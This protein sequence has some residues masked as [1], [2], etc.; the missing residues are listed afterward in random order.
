MIVDR[1]NGTVIRRVEAHA[2]FCSN[3]MFFVT[4]SYDIYFPISLLFFVRK[5]KNKYAHVATLTI[6]F[7]I[8]KFLILTHYCL[9]GIFH[10][11]VPNFFILI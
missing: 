11:A 3:A 1:N 10:L 2:Y 9:T 5:N 6:V 8:D 7:G 4:F